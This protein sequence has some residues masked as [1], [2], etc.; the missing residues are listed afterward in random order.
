MSE[1]LVEELK[2]KINQLLNDELLS[3]VS[4]SLSE[5]EIDSLI[6]VEKGQAFRIRVEREPLRPINLIVG[7]SYSV[8]DIK[9]LI[10]VTV[11]R[12]EKEEKT[13]R[14]RRISWKFIW[15]AYCLVFDGTKLLDDN[16]IV[17]QLGIKQHSV[18]KFTRLPHQKGRH[19]KA[20]KWY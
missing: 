3:D 14:K 1:H 16:V 8:K 13:G 2:E 19:S 20:W 5:K 17:S 18:L 12:M 6:A 11:E 10:Q 4:P 9:K 15:R 7:Q